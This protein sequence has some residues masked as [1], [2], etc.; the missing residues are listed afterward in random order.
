[1]RQRWRQQPSPNPA[2]NHHEF[3]ARIECCGYVGDD[4][5][6]ELRRHSRDKYGDVQWNIGYAHKLEC[7]VD[8]GSGSGG[9]YH[10]PG[11]SDGGWSA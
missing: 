2:A 9:R 10:W 7:D 11:R 4:H 6:Y 5:G 3:L 1:M 8:R